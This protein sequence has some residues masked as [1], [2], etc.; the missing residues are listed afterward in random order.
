MACCLKMIPSAIS[1]DSIRSLSP[2]V[3]SLT[4]SLLSKKPNLTE[5]RERLNASISILQQRIENARAIA[6]RIKVITCH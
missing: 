2:N 6:N 3:T 5:A 1:V 4:E